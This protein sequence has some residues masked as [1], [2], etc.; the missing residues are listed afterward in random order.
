[1]TLPTELSTIFQSKQASYKMVLILSLLK[2]IDNTGKASLNK[3]VENFHQY[4][5]DRQDN[6]EIIEK[7]DKVINKLDSL[8]TSQIRN[9]ILEN[10]FRALSSILLKEGALPADEYIRF[11][12]E[13]W[14]QL[15]EETKQELRTYALEDLEKYYFSLTASLSLHIALQQIMDNYLTSK[16]QSFAK[17]ELGQFVRREIP[18]GLAQLPY[19]DDRYKIQGSVGQGNWAT[20]PWIAI[21]N[22]SE[23]ETTQ[24]G[25]YVVY[26]F[27]EDMESVYL[28]L[29]PRCNQ[30]N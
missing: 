16:S 11:K 19:I 12:P 6:G 27:A 9:L 17:H 10:P 22:K 23:T 5:K 3:V 21:M 14:A 15:N 4:Y 2:S 26:L 13:I 30:A 1:M 18:E 20:I 24:Q 29:A 28:T 8:A 25:V 7:E